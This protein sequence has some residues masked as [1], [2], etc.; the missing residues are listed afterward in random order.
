MEQSSWR[1]VC[2]QSIS[3]SHC[4]ETSQDRRTGIDLNEQCR[5]VPERSYQVQRSLQYPDQN[6]KAYNITLNSIFTTSSKGIIVRRSG[7]IGIKHASA[8]ITGVWYPV[9]R[10]LIFSMKKSYSPGQPAIGYRRFRVILPPVD[11]VRLS[12]SSGRATCTPWP[13]CPISTVRTSS[14]EKELGRIQI[15]GQGRS[16]PQQ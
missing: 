6:S 16:Q 15:Q 13:T 14:S 9:G 3:W 5:A 4:R 7:A 2:I 12:I 1:A 8:K 10:R 11:V